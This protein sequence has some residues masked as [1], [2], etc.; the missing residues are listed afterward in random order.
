MAKVLDNRFKSVLHKFISDNP[1]DFIPGRLIL[2]NAM[3][4]IEVIYH[5]KISKRMR[6]KNVTL[7]LD[8]SKA[9]DRIDWLYL[10]QIMVKMGFATHWIRW[11]MMCV[12]IVDYFVIVNNES[13]GPIFPGRGFRQGDPLSLYLFILCAKGLSAHPEG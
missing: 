2:D 10:K 5:M 9:Y 4:A 1:S 8:I 6:D 13:V 11:I 12:E 7:K 3:I